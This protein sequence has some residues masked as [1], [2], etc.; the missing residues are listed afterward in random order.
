MLQAVIVGLALGG[1]YAIASA[2]LVITYTSSGILNFAFGA[3]A[4]FIARFYYYLHTQEN[5]GIVQ[6]AV[7]SIVIASP[8]LGVF[9]YAVLF[10]HLRLASPLIKVVATI[11]LLVA[12]PSIAVL[13]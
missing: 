9:L 11:G 2:G 10:R 5:W 12:I 7:V 1:V 13:I 4:Y 6:A 3:I 8:V